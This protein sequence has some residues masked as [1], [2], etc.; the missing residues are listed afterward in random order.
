MG[1]VS[2]ASRAKLYINT[3]LSETKGMAQLEQMAAG[4]PSVVHPKVY[5]HGANYTTGII[6]NKDID[7]YTEAIREIMEDST[8]RQTLRVGARKYVEDNYNPADIVKKYLEIL[9]HVS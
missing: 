5:C 4:V 3:S 9:E 1:H 7:E 6:V 8:L 2:L